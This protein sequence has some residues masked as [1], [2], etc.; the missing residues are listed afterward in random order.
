VSQIFVLGLTFALR[1]R[2]LSVNGFFASYW[3]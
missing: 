1:T 3:V 2:I